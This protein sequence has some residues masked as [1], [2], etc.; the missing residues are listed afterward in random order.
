MYGISRSAMVWSSI[1][2]QAGA[3]PSFLT[4]MIA[5]LIC[6]LPGNY[7]ELFRSSKWLSIIG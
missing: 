3:L 2:Q 4:F 7:S 5:L 1:L 6:K